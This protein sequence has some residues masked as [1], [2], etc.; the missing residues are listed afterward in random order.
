MKKE[1]LE[2]SSS[3]RR[4]YSLVLLV[5]MKFNKKRGRLQK[6]VMKMSAAPLGTPA[7]KR[8]PA[9]DNN[10]VRRTASFVRTQSCFGRQIKSPEI[11][12]KS[13]MGS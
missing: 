8:A 13:F 3:K 11:S 1:P 12:N 7:W 4:S 6:V 2:F 10:P 5:H 9:P